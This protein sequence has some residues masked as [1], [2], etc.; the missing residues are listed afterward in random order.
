MS[1]IS[2]QALRNLGYDDVA[3][4]LEKKSGVQFQVGTVTYFREAI[5][6][7]NWD[8][9]LETLEKLDMKVGMCNRL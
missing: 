8:D 5:L 4:G 9:A 6:E 1:S 3:A 7:G 2:S